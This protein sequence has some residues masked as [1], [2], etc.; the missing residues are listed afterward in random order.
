MTRLLGWLALMLLAAPLLFTAWVSFS[1]DSF[2]TPPAR[3]WSFRWYKAFVADSRWTGALFRSLLVAGSAAAVAVFAGAPLAFAVTRYRYQG[4]T[5]LSAGAVLPAIIPPAVLGMALLPFLYLLGLW[6]SMV[7]VIL[8]HGLLGLP[9][10]FLIVRAHLVQLDPQLEWAARGLGATPW[11]V[12]LRVTLPL[13]RPALIVA[14][15]TAFVLSLNESMLTIFIVTPQTET[16]P[17]VMWPQLRFAVSPLVAVASCVSTVTA[18]VAGVA[19][20]QLYAR[21]VRSTR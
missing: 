13:L 17:A 16:L 14:A 2:L 18:T 1:P 12:T 4:R 6:G 5:L 7:G 3:V 19:L 20:F 9:A 10:A 15:I 21:L 11:Q 8:V